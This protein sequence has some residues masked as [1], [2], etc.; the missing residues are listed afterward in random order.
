MRVKT[1]TFYFLQ[2]TSRWRQENFQL[3]KSYLTTLRRFL[4]EAGKKVAYK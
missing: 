4:R 1:V 3:K 2:G